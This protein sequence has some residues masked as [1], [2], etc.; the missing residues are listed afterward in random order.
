MVI[1]YSLRIII[2]LQTS[3]IRC[4]VYKSNE[5]G[6]IYDNNNGQSAFMTVYKSFRLH[7]LSRIADVFIACG[8][9]YVKSSNT[10]IYTKSIFMD[11]SRFAPSKWETALPCNDVPHWRGASLESAM[12]CPYWNVGQW[13]TWWY[14]KLTHRHRTGWPTFCR[15]F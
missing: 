9:N 12:F 15:H 6:T 1:H 11:V 14:N 4:S 2:Y 10:K 7:I 13:R 3:L 5:N 8:C